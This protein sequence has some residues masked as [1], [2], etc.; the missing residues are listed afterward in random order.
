MCVEFGQFKMELGSALGF[1]QRKEHEQKWRRDED[2]DVFR[3]Q[4]RAERG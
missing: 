4:G 2:G 3:E 1:W